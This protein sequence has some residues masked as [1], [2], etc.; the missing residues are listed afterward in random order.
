MRSAGQPW[1]ADRGGWLLEGRPQP[2][3]VRGAVPVPTSAHAA[4]RT[5]ECLAPIALSDACEPEPRTI[6]PWLDAQLPAAAI[7]RVAVLR[8]ALCTVAVATA[9]TGRTQLRRTRRP[10]CAAAEVARVAVA[11]P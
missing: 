8:P 7:A 3:G 4:R 10:R 1:F 2:T 9:R 6:A 11:G 5:L